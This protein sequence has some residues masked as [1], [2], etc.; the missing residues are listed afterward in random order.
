LDI[1][2]SVVSKK[3][4]RKAKGLTAPNSYGESITGCHPEERSDEGSAF[5]TAFKQADPFAALL[6]MTMHLELTNNS[7]R[8]VI[9]R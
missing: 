9:E 8:L 6:R 3:R 1:Y 7:T 5:A 2:Q 4:N